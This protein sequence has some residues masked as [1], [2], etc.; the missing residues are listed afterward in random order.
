MPRYIDAERL[1]E[2]VEDLNENHNTGITRYEYKR[3]SA[4]LWEFP[5]ADVV[6]R[7]KGKW[8]EICSAQYWQYTYE[9]YRCTNCGLP[10]DCA[11]RYCPNCGAEMEE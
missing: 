6:E 9:H 5:T 2:I 4:V 8:Q 11:F 7:K 10:A 3:I 1:D